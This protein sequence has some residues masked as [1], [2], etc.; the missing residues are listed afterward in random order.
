MSKEYIE[1]PT[2]KGSGSIMTRSRGIVVNSLCPICKGE[3]GH[4][5]P[6]KMLDVMYK[7]RKDD[8]RKLLYKRKK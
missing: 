6:S 5:F 2:C 4:E 7:K 1:C 8:L 3:G